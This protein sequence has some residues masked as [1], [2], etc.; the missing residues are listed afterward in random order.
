MC[1]LPHGDH[2]SKPHWQFLRQASAGAVVGPEHQ[3]LFSGLCPLFIL[4][5]WM[6]Q[7][8]SSCQ[9]GAEPPSSEPDILTP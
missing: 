6:S 2:P 1:W 3:K 5:L 4:K 7:T 9:A 8:L